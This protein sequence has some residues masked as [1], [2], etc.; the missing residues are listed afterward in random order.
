MEQ[1]V[2]LKTTAFQENSNDKRKFQ[3]LNSWSNR[4]NHNRHSMIFGMERPELLNDEHISKKNAQQ[5]IGII[6]GM[7]TI[8]LYIS[9]WF[10]EAQEIELYIA[11]SVFGAITVLCFIIIFTNNISIVVTKRLF[12]ESNVIIIIILFFD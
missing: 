2:E 7:I 3:N 11:C 6:F 9:S 1:K 10:F 4:H 8:I 12:K 5:L